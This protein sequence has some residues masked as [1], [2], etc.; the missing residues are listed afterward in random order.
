MVYLDGIQWPK[1]DTFETPMRCLGQ[2]K[3]KLF[4]F[5]NVKSFIEASDQEYCIAIT[6][7]RYILVRYIL[8]Y[9]LVFCTLIFN[10]TIEY[11]K[12]FYVLFNENAFYF[13]DN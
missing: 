11:F 12:K 6:R 10:F 4:Y 7:V 2:E 13:V 5:R 1:C 3:N 9:V 8:L